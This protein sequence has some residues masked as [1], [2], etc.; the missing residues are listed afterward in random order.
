MKPRAAFAASPAE[1]PP[2]AMKS[3]HQ[4]T[5]A[6]TLLAKASQDTTAAANTATKRGMSFFMA[7]IIP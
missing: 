4:F 6:A 7:G 5:M 1:S 2:A 3:L